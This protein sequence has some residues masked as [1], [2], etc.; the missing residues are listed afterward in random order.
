MIQTASEAL[1]GVAN[2]L[3]TALDGDGGWELLV[4]NDAYTE[5][6]AIRHEEDGAVVAWSLP[7]GGVIITNLASTTNSEGRA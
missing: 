7:A 2:I 4:P 1:R 3:D 5:L 6:G